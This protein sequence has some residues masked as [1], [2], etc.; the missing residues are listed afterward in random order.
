MLLRPCNTRPLQ[1]DDGHCSGLPSHLVR[2][3]TH[4]DLY[5]R[6]HDEVYNT[7]PATFYEPR[8]KHA[9]PSDLL[10]QRTSYYHFALHLAQCANKHTD[11][12]KHLICMLQPQA[13]FN[14]VPSVVPASRNIPSNRHS[15]TKLM[16]RSQPSFR[17][18]N[19]SVMSVSYFSSATQSV[20]VDNTY[21]AY[22]SDTDKATLTLQSFVVLINN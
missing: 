18:P 4:T 5:K 22:L 20:H 16:V 12:S 11:S 3:P 2:H 1:P 8:T 7:V 17:T 6:L 14:S 19:P 9:S 13:F 15:T 10:R 21:Q